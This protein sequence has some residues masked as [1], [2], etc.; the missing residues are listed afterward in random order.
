MKTFSFTYF[1]SKGLHRLIKTFSL[2]FSNSK[3]LHHPYQDLFPRIFHFKRSSSPLSRPFPSHFPIQKVFI[4]LIKTFSLAFSNSKG[5]HRPYQDL[6]PR[7]FQFKR[8]SSPLSR[9]FPSL[10][11]LQKVFPPTKTFSFIFQYKYFS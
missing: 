3:G 9:P 1:N 2:A 8:S 4:A 7:I 10:I 6:F 11:P 5:L